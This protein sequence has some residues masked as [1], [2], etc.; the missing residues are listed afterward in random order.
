MSG[1][2]TDFRDEASGEVLDVLG[3]VIE[4]HKVIDLHTLTPR[5][6]R[7]AKFVGKCIGIGVCYLVAGAIWT[8]RGVAWAVRRLKS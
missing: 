4:S 6:Q 8:A 5:Q 1:R 7:V 2:V 3:E